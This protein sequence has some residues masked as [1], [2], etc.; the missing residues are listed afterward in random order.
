MGNCTLR[1]TRYDISWYA[2]LDDARNMH[3]CPKLTP[4]HRCSPPSFFAPKGFALVLKVSKQTMM[5]YG[6]HL[7][8]LPIA[9][10]GG[11]VVCLC[12][13]CHKE[14][15]ASAP[16]K[17]TGAYVTLRGACHKPSLKHY[18]Q[19]PCIFFAFDGLGSIFHIPAP[20]PWRRGCETCLLLA[21]KHVF[22][23]RLL[24]GSQK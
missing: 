23:Y 17:P 8:S 19:I 11:F 12:T 1:M 13:A 10:C 24:R 14:I 4:L 2:I 9:C 5:L 22:P 15:K 18:C 3:T 21:E 20:A 6:C 16:L 7:R